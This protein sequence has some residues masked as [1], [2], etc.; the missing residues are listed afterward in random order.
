MTGKVMKFND[1][2]KRKVAE[3][4]KPTIKNYESLHTWV[5][6]L[7]LDVVALKERTEGNAASTAAASSGSGSSGGFNSVAPPGGGYGRRS[8][9]F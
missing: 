6:K 2:G 9:T 7:E 8:M 1:E 3:E 4:D 5:R